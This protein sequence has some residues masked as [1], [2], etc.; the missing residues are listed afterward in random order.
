MQNF[1]HITW[2]PKYLMSNAVMKEYKQKTPLKSKLS[3]HG[4]R[5]ILLSH[6]GIDRDEDSGYPPTPQH[7]E[8]FRIL[9]IACVSNLRQARQTLAWRSNNDIYS[10]GPSIA[11]HW[12]VEVYVRVFWWGKAKQNWCLGSCFMEFELNLGARKKLFFYLNFL[13]GKN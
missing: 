8:L 4:Y 3:L 1:L 2:S 13:L 5:I 7:Y 12:R 9:L 6:L 10:P 11:L